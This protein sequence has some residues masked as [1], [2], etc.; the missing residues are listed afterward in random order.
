MDQ[1]IDYRG[2]RK[3]ATQ[4]TYNIDEEA[5]PLVMGVDM[6]HGHRIGLIP[7]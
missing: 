4:Y 1:V 3:D 6:Q 5:V 2:D 7:N